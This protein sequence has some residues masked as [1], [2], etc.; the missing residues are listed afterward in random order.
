MVPPWWAPADPRRWGLGD[1]GYGMLIAFGGQTVVGVLLV[2]AGVTGRGRPRPA[3]VGHPAQR[4]RGLAR[5]HRLAGGGVVR[6]GSAQPGAGLRL[7][8]Q[9][10]RHRLGRA[11]WRRGAR[12]NRSRSTCSGSWSAATRPPT[13]PVFCPIR[14]S[15]LEATGL[16]DRRCR[17]HAV[18]RRAVLPR[19]APASAREAL[20]P[21]DRD[22]WVCDRLRLAAHRWASRQRRAWATSR[23]KG[24]SSAW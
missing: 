20:Q 13:T 1:V 2:L 23:C 14:P 12:D 5:F 24:C 6:E 18:R 4:C 21:D 8:V 15:V 9:A 7:E 10:G 17:D 19:P 22:R 11:R 3:A 16:F